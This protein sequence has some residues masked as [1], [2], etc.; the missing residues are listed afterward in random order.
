MDTEIVLVVLFAIF[1]M[2]PGTQVL[3]SKSCMEWF[4][5]GQ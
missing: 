2:L 3:A 1:V 5:V 4:H